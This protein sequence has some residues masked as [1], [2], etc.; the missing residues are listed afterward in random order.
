VELLHQI[1]KRRS[2]PGMLIF[3]KNNRLLY[4]NR[5]ALEMIPDLGKSVKKARRKGIPAEI[6]NLLE[7]LKKSRDSKGA[8]QAADLNGE[9][10]ESHSGNQYSARA[11]FIGGHDNPSSHILVLVEKII[12]RHKID[13]EKAKKEFHL[14]QREMEVLKIIS[15]GF[16]NREISEKLF[17]SEYTVKDHLKKI[18]RKMGRKSRGAIIASLK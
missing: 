10:L 12:E 1:I 6:L 7:R 5:E 13:F 16:N 8:G 17:I 15:D 4:S 2:T 18:M 11:F 14:S 3:D 9:V